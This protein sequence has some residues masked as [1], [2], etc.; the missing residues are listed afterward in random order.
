VLVFLVSFEGDWFHLC[1]QRERRLSSGGWP[2]RWSTGVAPTS[3]QCAGR[4]YSETNFDNAEV[5]TGHA[6]T[7]GTWSVGR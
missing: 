7:G 4:A 2:C 1:H 3:D 5:T 6:D